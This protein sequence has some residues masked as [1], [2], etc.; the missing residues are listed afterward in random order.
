MKLIAVIDNPL[1]NEQVKNSRFPSPRTTLLG[2]VAASL[3]LLA[4][5]AI[6][7]M[8]FLQFQRRFLLLTFMNSLD[9]LQ[10]IPVFL[11]PI[12]SSLA[13]GRIWRGRGDGAEGG[14]MTARQAAS[15]LILG[16][17]YRLRVLVVLMLVTIPIMTWGS[18]IGRAVVFGM[19]FRQPGQPARQAIFDALLAQ[20]DDAVFLLQLIGLFI[21]GGVIGAA[22][23]VKI[24]RQKISAAVAF[25]ITLILWAVY[26]VVVHSVPR[27]VTGR[28]SNAGLNVLLSGVL[29]L[30][31]L[32]PLVVT[33]A[34]SRLARR[35]V[36]PST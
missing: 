8:L 23:A 29:G 30:L 20:G 26:Q 27:S 33:W 35:W 2:G 36:Q 28:V 11:M 34:A 24:D 22:L 31:W 32:I 13:A 10:L 17:F 9:L 16:V 18:G 15:G 25:L 5:E 3:L 7:Y 14:S 12:L 6:R 1:L 19:I 21:M 4:L